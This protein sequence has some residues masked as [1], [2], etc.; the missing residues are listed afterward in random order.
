MIANGCLG[1]DSEGRTIVYFKIVYY[2]YLVTKS[3]CTIFFCSFRWPLWLTVW[4]ISVFYRKHLSSE[5][6][7]DSH[8]SATVTSTNEGQQAKKVPRNWKV[9][10][11]KIY[12]SSRKKL[13]MLSNKLYKIWSE[14]LG[15]RTGK[16]NLSETGYHWLKLGLS[17]RPNSVGISPSPEN[18]NGFSLRNVLSCS[19]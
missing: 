9:T 5:L 4:K 17:K 3:Q 13:N 6:Y 18:A 12:C 7:L 19:S 16:Y 2:Y 11:N 10:C 8:R 15:F 14:L 1:K